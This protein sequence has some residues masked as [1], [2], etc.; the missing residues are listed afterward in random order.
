MSL[1]FDPKYVNPGTIKPHLGVWR[2][3]SEIDSRLTLISRA[4]DTGDL[5]LPISPA[6][7]VRWADRINLKLPIKMRR[8]VGA[9]A[10]P[11]D[12][13]DGALRQEN[14]R[15]KK[16]LDHY[17]IA[18]RDTHPR[19]LRSLQIILAAVAHCKYGFDPAADRNSATARI[20]NDIQLI[21]QNLD[22]DTV[23]THLRRAFRDLE[24]PLPG[25]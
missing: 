5:V 18:D 9:L 24:I 13:D 4:L 7:F 14:D 20:V 11:S 8:A 19:E 23:L 17:K 12:N 25:V 16:E 2:E 6:D 15:L 1:G 21:G 22:K 3:A 10:K